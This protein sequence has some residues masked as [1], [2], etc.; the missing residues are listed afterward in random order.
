[1]SQALTTGEGRCERIVVT[2]WDGRVF[3]LGSPDS[4]LF[5]YRRRKYLRARRHEIPVGS[6]ARVT[7]ED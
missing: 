7:Q 6:L 3:D 4:R 2:T 5:A 1:M